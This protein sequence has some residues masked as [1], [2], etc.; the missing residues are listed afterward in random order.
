MPLLGVL[1]CVPQRAPCF[2]PLCPRRTP[3]EAVHL[4][5]VIANP[6]SSYRFPGPETTL[7]FSTEGH[8]SS[9]ATGVTFRLAGDQT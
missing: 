9:L 5:S 6:P 7:L 2:R 4:S 8:P 3:G 1:P